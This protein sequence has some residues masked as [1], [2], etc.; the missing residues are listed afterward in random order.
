[1]KE[2]KTL[3]AAVVI[4]G[5]EILSG[6]TQDA[7]I[8]W[9]AEKLGAKGIA[10]IEIRVVPDTAEK[11]IR[12][13]NELRGEVDYLFTTGGIGPTHDDI[14]AESVARAFGVGLEQ[15]AEAL[16]ILQG[17]YGDESA[18]N[19]ARLKMT[20]IPRGAALIPNPVSGAPGFVIGNVHVMAG[21][22]GIMRGMLDSV[23]PGLRGG[24]VVYSNTVTCHLAESAV[25]AELSAL[26][27]KFPQVSIG[28]YPRFKP[29]DMAL[30]L[31]LR[32]TEKDLLKQATRELVEIV[33]RMEGKTPEAAG[34]EI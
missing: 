34:D 15:S 4:I 19:E 25:A 21:V 8:K 20:M 23:L 27:E 9:I 26:Q 28:S 22:P 31:V 5:D 18:L 29:G 12:A 17:H 32:S 16:T 14:T 2:S 33:K 3:S 7:N 1:M 10:L 24:A 6:R 30:S 13:V 11:I